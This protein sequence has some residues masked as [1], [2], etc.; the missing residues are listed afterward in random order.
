MTE[1][2]KPWMKWYPADWRAEPKLRLCSRAARSLWMDLLGL[3]H[4]AEPYGY[5]LVQGISPTE[6]QIAILL[7]DSEKDVKKLMAEL[8]KIGVYS[9]TEEGVIYSRRMVRDQQKAERDRNNG[10]RGGNPRLKGQDNQRHNQED[11]RRVNPPDN[12]EVKAQRLEAR[13]QSSV[14][15]ATDASASISETPKDRLWREGIP[16]LVA[17]TG[18]TEAAI[19]PLV[20][21]WCKDHSPA[22]VL[23]AVA[24]AQAESAIEP[25][26][27]ITRCL[28]PRQ[29]ETV[30]DPQRYRPGG[31]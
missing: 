25:I 15:K 20:G 4:E 10:G 24:R 21:K 18:K 26:G 6:N 5:L 13:G 9:I 19:R 28:N 29:G 30:D 31:L 11:N 8:R 22:E 17:K 16:Y 14:A 23:D 12:S 1:K 7:G 3:M 2:R 27:F